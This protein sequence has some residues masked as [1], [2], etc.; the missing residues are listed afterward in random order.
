MDG[1][2]IEL[3]RLQRIRHEMGLYRALSPYENV[4]ASDLHVIE[5]VKK[6][7]AKGAVQGYGKGYL[8]THM[9]QHGLTAAR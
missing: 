9:R 5:A 7:L 6:E 3:R 1:H 2:I 4:L 8:Y